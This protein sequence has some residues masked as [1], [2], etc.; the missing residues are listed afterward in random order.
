MP[1]E[2]CGEVE[3]PR[4]YRRSPRTVLALNE[5]KALESIRVKVNETSAEAE[6]RLLVEKFPLP[7][8]VAEEADEAETFLH[9]SRTLD[10]MS[11][12]A[13]NGSIECLVVRLGQSKRT[14]EARKGIRR[15]VFNLTA[16]EDYRAHLNAIPGMMKSLVEACRERDP[17]AVAA[18]S[19][20]AYEETTKHLIVRESNS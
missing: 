20:L 4:G 18:L 12:M 6:A 1:D 11:M 3:Q 16:Q 13:E 9:M 14:P 2:E 7:T 15:A 5:A 10:G 19:N 17:V 8:T